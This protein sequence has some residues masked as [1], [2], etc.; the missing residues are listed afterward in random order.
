M[1][2]FGRINVEPV[3]IEISEFR[4]YHVTQAG[5]MDM[6]HLSSRIV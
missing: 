6:D 5:V 2:D 1:S 4:V 3:L